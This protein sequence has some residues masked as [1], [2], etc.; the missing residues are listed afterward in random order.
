[1]WTGVSKLGESIF[2][3]GGFLNESVF[4]IKPT[5]S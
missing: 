2:D 3:K 1:M 4:G 5:K